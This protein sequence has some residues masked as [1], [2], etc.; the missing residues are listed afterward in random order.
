M[1]DG[2]IDTAH[3]ALKANLWHNSKEVAGNGKDDDNNGYADDVYGWNFIGGRDGKSVHQ[4]ALEVT[5][6]YARCGGGNGA[7]AGSGTAAKLPPPDAATCK[8]AGEEFEKERWALIQYLRTL[9]K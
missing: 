7:T 3:A 9:K 8:R 4:D 2:G 1:I 6:L 5:R